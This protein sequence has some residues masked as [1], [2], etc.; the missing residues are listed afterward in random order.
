M[1]EVTFEKVDGGYVMN[2][3]YFLFDPPDIPAEDMKR[4][5]KAFADEID[6]RLCELVMAEIKT[7]CTCVGVCTCGS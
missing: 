1:I 5:A 3:S 6:A 7:Y 2:K 4:I